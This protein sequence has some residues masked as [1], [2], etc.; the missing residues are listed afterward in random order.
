MNCN[1]CG[2][3]SDTD[4]CLRADCLTYGSGAIVAGPSIRRTVTRCTMDATTANQQAIEA[5]RARLERTCQRIETNEAT[6]YVCVAPVGHAG[7]CHPYMIDAMGLRGL[8]ADGTPV[9][10][11]RFRYAR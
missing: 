3:P 8:A 1:A 9:Y 10:D 2:R 4:F 6:D 7:P 11:P 5:D